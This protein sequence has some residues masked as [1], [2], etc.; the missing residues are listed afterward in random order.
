LHT[1]WEVAIGSGSYIFIDKKEPQIPGATT[2]TSIAGVVS[3]MATWQF[4]RTS[5]TFAIRFIWYRIGTSYS[6]DANIWRLGVSWSPKFLRQRALT[7][8]SVGVIF[9]HSGIDEIGTQREELIGG[10][11]IERRELRLQE[12]Q[13]LH[14]AALAQRRVHLDAQICVATARIASQAATCRRE[15]A[16][17]NDFSC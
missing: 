2:S 10:P 15:K 13:V 1:Y 5:E 3:G 9:C 14:L 11:L 8:G 16:G 6:C 17:L 7:P 12:R 4:P